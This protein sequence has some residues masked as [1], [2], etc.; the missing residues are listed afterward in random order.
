MKIG[1]FA[2]QTGTSIRML[3]YYEAEG[4]LTPTRTASGYRDYGQ[5]EKNIIER[6]KLLGAAGMTLPV[7]L[8]FLPCALDARAEFEPCD[9]LR[10]IL[11]Q[12]VALVDQRVDKLVQSRT[13]LS[14]LLT[15]LDE[16]D[17]NLV[18]TQA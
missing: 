14:E 3:R 1:E 5:A 10:S 11:R 8:Q 6:I 17:P 13:L 7:I 2:R 18:E 15:T 9:E 4:L 16:Q 12:H